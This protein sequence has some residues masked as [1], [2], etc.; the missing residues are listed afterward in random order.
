MASSWGGTNT[1]SYCPCEQRRH[2]ACNFYPVSPAPLTASFLL[3][4]RGMYESGG[5]HLIG[6]QR[7]ADHDHA[8]RR[9]IARLPPSSHER[10]PKE[11]QCATVNLYTNHASRPP[12]TFSFSG[13]FV[14]GRLSPFFSGDHKPAQLVRAP[15]HQQP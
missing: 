1:R 4:F 9:Q 12:T 6:R 13:R 2:G 14:V 3:L 7:W 5:T 10:R 15:E 11:S 8:P